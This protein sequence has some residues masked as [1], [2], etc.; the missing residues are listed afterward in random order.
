M[1]VLFSSMRMAGHVRP[2]LPYAHALRDGGHEV[3]VAAPEGAGAIL[4]DAALPHA[5]FGHPGDER[6]G[7]IWATFAQMSPEEILD[8]V[9]GKIFAGLNARAALPGLRETIRT[10]KPDIIVRESCEFAAVIAAAEEGIPIA[11]VATSNRHAE[12]AGQARA[13]VSVDILRRDAGLSAD[14]GAAMRAEPSF[15]SFPPS[16]DG[17]VVAPDTAPPFRVRSAREPVDPAEAVP[18]WAV[19]DGRP[20]VYITFG[21]LAA[22]ST[23]NHALF[24]AAIEAAAALPVRALLSTGAEMDRN[25]LG[26]VPDNV[27]VMPW[28]PQGAV[29]PRAA[30]LVCHGGAGTVLAGLTYGVPMVCTPLGADQP[31][32]ACRVEAT[33]AGIALSVHDAPSLRAA[34]E[35]ALADTGMRASADRVAREIAALASMDDAVHALERLKA[36]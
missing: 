2:L 12:V 3:M 22:G 9:M 25:L 36:S 6:L 16:I 5:V 19:D 1:R 20:L 35:R 14:H 32:N 7:E 31:D 33:G 8:A 18:A 29:F 15:T 23:R 21:T 4:R 30:A 17:D 13:V 26:T 10:W 27:T 11:R 34:M 24:R 28:V